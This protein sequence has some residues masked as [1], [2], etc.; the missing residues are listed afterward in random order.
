MPLQV[1]VKRAVPK[2]DA[3]PSVKSPKDSPPSPPSPVKVSKKSEGGGGG[4]GND[5]AEEKVSETSQK[6]KSKGTGVMQIPKKPSGKTAWGAAGA[7][8]II[9]K[10]RQES[11]AQQP[12]EAEGGA[13]TTTSP[14]KTKEQQEAAAPP[15]EKSE[16]NNDEEA[17]GEKSE[18]P[19]VP[20]SPI[21][22]RSKKGG[23]WGRP[24]PGPSES[25][26]GAT[27]KKEKLTG[28]AALGG[29]VFDEVSTRRNE[30]AP[31]ESG[32]IGDGLSSSREKE[33]EENVVPRPAGEPASKSF[34]ETH[35][36][37]K[38]GGEEEPDGVTIDD[39]AG[40][41]GARLRSV[42]LDNS[43]SALNFGLNLSLENFL[44]HSEGRVPASSAQ[45]SGTLPRSFGLSGLRDET[46]TITE[47]Q[48]LGLSASLNPAVSV[49]EGVLG[50]ED[51]KRSSLSAEAVPFQGR[52]PQHTSGAE[53]PQPAGEGLGQGLGW[54][55]PW[56][57]SPPMSS[58]A[59]R[60]LTPLYPPVIILLHLLF[61]FR[62]LGRKEKPCTH[63]D[64][65]SASEIPGCI[66]HCCRP[67]DARQSLVLRS[68]K[69]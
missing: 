60:N 14:V 15:P 20:M 4:G 47:S 6:S 37:N 53:A 26:T 25:E 13:A 40:L 65:Q 64:K 23:A 27:T 39:A 16:T 49:L 1:E 46:D 38:E 18:Q 63:S 56:G 67:W 17:G 43:R 41:M 68:T 62:S 11:G 57:T 54:P 52:S 61:G 5:D 28:S 34:D 19:S 8:P 69:L 10:L 29:D 36:R 9:A 50:S 58:G 42:S 21:V 32:S 35:K 33:H 12:K 44:P 2:A 3:P 30:R 55:S 7:K 48:D 31:S 51:G 22:S 66:A 24:P 59:S 45:N